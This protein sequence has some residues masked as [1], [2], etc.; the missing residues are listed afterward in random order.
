MSPQKDVI[1]LQLGCGENRLPPPWRNYDYDMD[2]T[3]PLPFADNSARIVF[4]EHCLEH[5]SGPDGFRF[6]KEAHRILEPQG[7]LRICVPELERME[8]TKKED[9]IVNHGH[10]M[11]YCWENL[12]Q[13]LLAAGFHHDNIRLSERMKCDGHWRVIGVEEDDRETLRVEATKWL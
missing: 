11:V 4:I 5:V 10:L 8:A 1:L 2:I 9:L 7:V 13:M 12:L 6:M 3:K